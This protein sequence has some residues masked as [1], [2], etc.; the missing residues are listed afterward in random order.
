MSNATALL[1]GRMAAEAL[2]TD[3]GI[4]RRPNGRT[5]QDPGTGSESPALDDLF[6]SKAKI[7]T[8]QLQAQSA[9]VGGR[10]A[11]AVQ[12]ELHLPVSAPAVQAGDV[13]EH[14]SVSSL[15]DMQLL[16][17]KFRVIAPVGK[18]FATA[19]RLEVEEIVA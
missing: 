12:V 10:T 11:V 5:T 4:M 7:Q 2:M 18:T 6:T 19:R 3:A 1:A 14:T 17:R 13:W 8:R 9:D 15:S 16:G